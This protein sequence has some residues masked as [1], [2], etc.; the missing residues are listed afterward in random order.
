MQMKMA[1]ESLSLK[2]FLVGT[3]AA[4]LVSC[5]VAPVHGMAELTEQMMKARNVE[6]LQAADHESR[7]EKVADR[8]LRQ[9]MLQQQG[10]KDSLH[11]LADQFGGVPGFYHGVASGT[12]PSFVLMF[13]AGRLV[14]SCW[15]NTCWWPSVCT[16]FDGAASISLSYQSMSRMLS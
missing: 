9:R 12:S 7:A 8:R 4:I 10:L 1:R 6:E 14:F 16:N 15:L 11:I 2:L 13:L 5:L 3:A